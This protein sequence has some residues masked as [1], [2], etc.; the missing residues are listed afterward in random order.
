MPEVGS[1]DGIEDGVHTFPRKAANFFHDVLTPVIDGDA[2]QL[3]LELG[4][5]GSMID[6][7]VGEQDLLHRHAGGV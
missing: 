4:R 5:A 2:A 7:P 6:M 1:P 3:L